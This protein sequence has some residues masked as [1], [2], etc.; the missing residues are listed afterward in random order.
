[1]HTV[2]ETASYLTAADEVGLSEAERFDVVTKLAA[3]PASGD[4]IRGTGG[5]RKVR[6]AGRGKGESGGYR[7]VTFYSGVN[8]PVFLLTVF[9]KGQ[10]SDLSR[11]EQNA[12][13]KLVATLV[14][15]LSK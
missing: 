12:Q 2:I 10:K 1:M 4:P 15:S 5:C 11:A 8:V 6:V 3:N 7:I 13:A 9:G 14:E